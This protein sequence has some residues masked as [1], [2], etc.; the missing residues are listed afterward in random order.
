MGEN[1]N[2]IRLKQ[3]DDEIAGAAQSKDC[4]EPEWH[5]YYK[6]GDIT[7]KA[8]NGL[9]FKADKWKLAE[10]SE[11]FASICEAAT[12]M[13]ISDHNKRQQEA[14]TKP[15]DLDASAEFIESFLNLISVSIL[16]LPQTDLGHTY[17]LL[18][19]CEMFLCCERIMTLVQEEMKDQLGSDPWAALY[20]AFTRNDVM[21]AR[22]ALGHMDMDDFCDTKVEEVPLDASAALPYAPE[23][24]F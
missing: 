16:V 23:S 14:N 22:E 3:S 6:Q 7:F 21:L 18:K 17:D 9:L 20:F 12:P 10:A 24:T 15:L 8:S 13:V 1:E 2:D 4:D 5:W 11:F 19:L